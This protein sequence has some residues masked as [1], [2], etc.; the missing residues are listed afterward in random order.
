MSVSLK[1]C[2]EDTVTSKYRIPVIDLCPDDEIPVD[3]ADEKCK[4][5]A[6]QHHTA[7]S[8]VEEVKKVNINALRKHKREC[9]INQKIEGKAENAAPRV[10]VLDT[11]D[12]SSG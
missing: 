3:V 10:I 12:E 7:L 8:E 11:S 1:N 5:R 6:K 9:T 4:D 2:S